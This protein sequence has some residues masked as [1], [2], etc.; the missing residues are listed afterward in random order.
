V[1][2]RAVAGIAVA[3]ISAVGRIV[4]GDSTAT[5]AYDNR[6][7]KANT[8]AN[9]RAIRPI[10]RNPVGFGALVDVCGR[11]GGGFGFGWAVGGFGGGGLGSGG[12]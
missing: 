2:D 9:T 5:V 10:S 3:R 8:P 4:G 12:A 1:G 6:V 11:G 7:R